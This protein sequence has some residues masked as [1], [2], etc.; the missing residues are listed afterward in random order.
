M[1]KTIYSSG[2]VAD[3]QG[4]LDLV[5]P[6]LWLIRDCIFDAQG[7][8]VNMFW[9]AASH[10]SNQ[11]HAPVSGNPTDPAY[12]LTHALRN[13]PQP[14][15]TPS[16]LTTM[17]DRVTMRVRLVPVG[18]DVLDDLIDGGD[19]DA[20]VKAAMPTFDLAGTT[21]EWTAATVTNNYVEDGL[22]VACVS[23]GLSTG[24]VG[25]NPAPMHTKC[26]P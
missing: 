16:V 4:V 15:S 11:L 7:H 25:A 24:G 2:V 21:L 6:D 1:N 9:Q 17:P 14:T 8:P 22:P 10:D 3:G 13:Y 19:L 26:S 5:D 20:G 23:A 18:L 12:Y